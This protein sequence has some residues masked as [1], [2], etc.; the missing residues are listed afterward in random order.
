MQEVS[1]TGDDSILASLSVSER[2]VVILSGNSSRYIKR[3]M[4]SDRTNVFRQCSPLLSAQ[5][6][7]Y[8]EEFGVELAAIAS[9]P[10]LLEH[11]PLNSV[12]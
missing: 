6:S 7:I 8:V 12:V 4:P 9:I 2:H 1:Q 3:S 11:N 10:N 5:R